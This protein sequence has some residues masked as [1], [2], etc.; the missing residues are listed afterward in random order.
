MCCLLRLHVSLPHCLRLWHCPLPLRLFLGGARPDA[1][2]PP[3]SK[4]LG[5]PHHLPAIS[6]HNIWKKDIENHYS[7]HISI[8][9]QKCLCRLKMCLSL[10]LSRQIFSLQKKQ[11]AKSF[12]PSHAIYPIRSFGLT[13][14]LTYLNVSLDKVPLFFLA[15]GSSIAAAFKLLFP[16][17]LTACFKWFYRAVWPLFTCQAYQ[18]LVSRR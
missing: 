3:G 4:A 5:H 8:L 12:A 6:L 10:E 18:T 14:T 16:C 1:L 15:F 17:L 9:F 2:S 7:H 13:W 11:T